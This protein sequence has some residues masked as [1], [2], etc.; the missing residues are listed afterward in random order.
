MNPDPDVA[1]GGVIYKLL[2]RSFPNFYKANSVY[3]MYPFTL[4]QENRKIQASLGH[5][6][7]YDYSPPK[8]DV[9]PLPV[10]THKAVVQIL[11]DQARFKVPWGIATY[12]LTKHDY[13]L[14]GDNPSNAAQRV[15]VEKQLYCPHDGLDDIRQFYEKVTFAMLR[16]RSYKLR[17]YYQVDAVRDIG[18]ASHANF[19]ATMFHIPLK[20]AEHP[21]GLFTEQEIYTIFA[22][23]FAFIFLNNDPASSFALKNG[24]QAALKPL[25]LTLDAV[26]RAVQHSTFLDPI[27]SILNMHDTGI[28]KDFGTHLIKRL[29]QGDKSADEVLWTIIP[30]AAAMVATMGQAFAQML[31]LYLSDKYKHHWADISEAAQSNS[32]ADFEKLRKYALEGQR[33]NPASFGL[34]RIAAQDDIEIQDGDR[35]LKINKGDQVFTNFVSAGMDPEAFPEPE[36]IKLDRPE[37]SYI[38]HG[39]GPHACLGRPIVTT[40]LAAQLRI[41][42]RL[43][44]LRRAP[45]LQ[46]EL[47]HKLVNGAIKVYM[48]ED[49]SSWW[50]FPSSKSLAA[51][52][53]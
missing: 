48:R 50:F 4:P 35:D 17:D 18:N 53:S 8:L 9:A 46:G 12:A 51:P 3:A 22:V 5:E 30:T 49:W 29:S 15:F 7:V 25:S 47:K 38:H 28:I 19:T 37:E 43:K 13:M 2:M 31:D 20:T 26:V 10:L 44:N 36:E 14:S 11:D 16:E 23:L 42:G 33:L 52:G 1:H 40:A 45:G 32:S 24:A 27:K 21:H 41:F 39:H 34:V 6:D